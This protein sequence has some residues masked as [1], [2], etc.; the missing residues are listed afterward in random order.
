MP[1]NQ[2][3]TGGCATKMLAAFMLAV[4][5]IVVMAYLTRR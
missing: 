1:K 5:L 4:L 3:P 2:G